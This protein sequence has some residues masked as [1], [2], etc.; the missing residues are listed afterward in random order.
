MRIFKFT[1]SLENLTKLKILDLSNNKLTEFHFDFTKLEHLATVNLSNNEINSFNLKSSSVHILDLSINKFVKFPEIPSCTM[2]L[3]LNKNEIAELPHEFD[4]PHLKNLD[5]SDNKIVEVPKELGSLKLKVFNMKNNPLK[6]KKL[7]RFIQQN[8]AIKAIMDHIIKLG[9]SSPI[10]G[11]DNKSSEKKIKEVKPHT[12]QITINKFDENFKIIYDSSVKNERRFIL[13]CIISNIKFTQSSFKEFISFQ[14]KLHDGICDQRKL[15]TIA[16]HDFD[17]LP[18]KILRF[19]A[20]MKDE[21]Q[22]QPLG[23]HKSISVD[24]YLKNLNAEAEALRKAKKRSVYS[25]IY[26]YLNHF[27][28]IFDQQEFAILESDSGITLSF[29]PLT[30]SELTKLN[31]NSKRMLIEITS[32][33]SAKDCENVMTLLLTKALELSLSNDSD[34]MKEIEIEQVRILNNDGDLKTIFPSKTDLQS[35][36]NENLKIIRN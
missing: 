17:L 12:S 27:P 14:T 30:N 34:E 31:L 24:E 10:N 23:R 20:K 8:Q 18:T 36:E 26:K 16:T 2:D 25:G 5:L 35:L 29:P 4:L 6:D 19:T 28:N 13:C 21:I 15:A 1:E 7:H 9:I 3:K 11:N 32:G 33:S 22:I